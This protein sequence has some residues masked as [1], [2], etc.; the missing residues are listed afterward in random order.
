MSSI[1]RKIVRGTGRG[2][3]SDSPTTAHAPAERTLVAQPDGSTIA[4]FSIDM[5]AVPLPE[6]RY[7]ADG[8][9]IVRHDGNDA[10]LLVF[11]QRGVMSAARSLV[12]VRMYPEGIRNFVKSF[13]E[14][15]PRVETFVG[16]HAI[17][18]PDL[19]IPKEE[20]A[21]SVALSA[22]VVLAAH[23]AREAELSFFHLSPM[24]VYRAGSHNSAQIPVDS[25]VRVELPTGLLLAM[26][27]KLR[28][29]EAELPKD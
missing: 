16:Q 20:P 1:S 27:R 17:K 11:S 13:L 5:S 14:F 15:L 8:A 4:H 29:L 28:A 2:G 19:E 24:L 26:M 18:V 23:T 22:S 9:G 6:R 12:E 3:V 25:V 7:S 21:Q 10:V